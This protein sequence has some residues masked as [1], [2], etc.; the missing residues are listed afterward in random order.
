LPKGLSEQLKIFANCPYCCGDLSH[1][2]AHLDHIHPVSK[3]G[4]ST[5]RNLVFVCSKFN[6]KKKD[7]T[8]G[9]Y[10]S[11]EKINILF[12]HEILG[13]LRKDF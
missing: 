6:L 1:S 7:K 8:L 11:V 13:K 12:V 2:S 3:G 4:L 10:C 5:N 9:V